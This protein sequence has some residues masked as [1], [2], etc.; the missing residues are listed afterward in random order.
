[1]SLA[2]FIVR[3]FSGMNTSNVFEHGV[4][5]VGVLSSLCVGCRF[6]PYAHQYV[7]RPPPMEEIHGKWV[8]DPDR[9]EWPAMKAFLEDGTVGPH[10]GFLIIETPQEGE[11]LGRFRIEDLPKFW[12]SFSQRPPAWDPVSPHWSGE[13]QWMT[14]TSL[15]GYFY[16]V[17]F[18]DSKGDKD[19]T[20]EWESL[21]VRRH[22]GEYLLH[23]IV[24][25]PDSGEAL[26]LRKAAD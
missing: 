5:L 24:R 20:G 10:R 18:F 13:G 21:Y 11:G 2:L 8:V 23:Y 26:V 15:D 14:R 22:R 7:K 19:N 17:L 1:M 3:Q 9:T 6:D 25:D 16:L 12:H 4:I